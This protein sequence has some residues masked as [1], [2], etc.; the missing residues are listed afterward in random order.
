MI[1]VDSS[2]LVR[3]LVGEPAE[4]AR[5]AQAVIEGDQ[6]VAIPVVVLLETAHVLRTQ[7][8]VERRDV[9]DTLLELVT[10]T[11]VETLGVNRGL[12]IEALVRARELPGSPL[13]DALVAAT[14]RDAGA[15][16][17]F[18]FDR[19]LARHGVLVQEP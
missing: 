16:P 1:S 3:Y 10:R 13:P 12:V 17:L 2:V 11:G 6:P 8:G 7:Y 9:L 5:R 4:Q 14:V 19:D 18:T 15:V